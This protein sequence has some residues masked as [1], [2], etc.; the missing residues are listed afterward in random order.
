MFNHE[1]E[2]KIIELLKTN[3]SA[4]VS[5]LSEIFGVSE[6]TI[7]RDLERLQEIGTIKRVHGGAVF[8][9]KAAP[10]P[11]VILRRAEQSQEKEHIGKAA[12]GLVKNG[13]T[14]FIGSGTTTEALVVN[15]KGRTDL[16]VITNSM[17]VVNILA[18]EEGITVISTGGLF[19]SSE[20]SFIGYLTEQA[21]EEL[22]PSKVFMGIRAISLSRGLTNDYM[23]EVSTDRVIINAAPEII[24]MADHAKF[25]KVSTV[26]VA[27]LSAVHKIITDSNTPKSI[28][29]AMKEMGI[30]VLVA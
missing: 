14:I 22:R 25:G 23:P 30:E 4:R 17:I 6:T 16:T 18:Q 15:L 29:I 2:R 3:S 1:R 28:V 5:D 27:P 11:P 19:R 13:E 7:R 9:E 8:S 10:E 24:L 20:Y 21:L 12:A 26:F